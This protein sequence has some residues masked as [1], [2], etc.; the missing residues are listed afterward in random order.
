MVAWQKYGEGK[1]PES[2]HIKSDHFVGDW[3]V[4]FEIEFQ[5]EYKV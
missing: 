1:T 2:E 5:K 4:R 3:Y